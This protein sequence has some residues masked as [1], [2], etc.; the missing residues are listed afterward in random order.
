MRSWVLKTNKNYNVQT[1]IYIDDVLISLVS[2]RPQI[3]LMGT[4]GIRQEDQIEGTSG[5]PTK[6]PPNVKL[7]NEKSLRNL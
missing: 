3:T 6:N 1:F 4:C 5:V 7:V 2:C